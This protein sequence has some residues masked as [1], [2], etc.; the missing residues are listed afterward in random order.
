MR[1]LFALVLL[2]AALGAR[3]GTLEGVVIVVI[4]GDTILFRP[5]HYAKASR[6]FLKVRL[7]GIDAPESSQPHGEAASV[8]LRELALNRR[9]TLEIVA[10][11]AYGRKLGRLSLGGIDVNA[12]LVRRG[13]AWAYGSARRSGAESPAV[14]ARGR[15]AGALR[16]AER[17][18]RRERRGLWQDP[19]PTPPWAWRREQ[20]PVPHR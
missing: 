7:A 15:T 16:L 6:A 1:L 17:E 2:V 4:D 20:P 18:A 13:H 5:D 19:E 9:A 10:T 12:E 8:A 3:A 14:S 11:D